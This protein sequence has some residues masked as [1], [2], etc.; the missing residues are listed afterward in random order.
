MKLCMFH[1]VDTP[2]ERGWVGRIEGD[3]VV[4]LAA[5][6]LQHLF[7]GGGSARDHARYRARRRRARRPARLSPVGPRLRR[8]RLVRVRESGGA[9]RARGAGHGPAGHHA[10]RARRR[11]RRARR[12][13]GR[14]CGLA[15]RTRSR[16]GAAPPKDRDFAI[17]LGPWF[18]TLDEAPPAPA[19]TVDVADAPHAEATKT[20]RLG[21]GQGVRRS[22]TPGS[23]SATFCS[24][25]PRPSWRCSRA[26]PSRSTSRATAP[27][28]SPLPARPK[29]TTGV[30]PHLPAARR[31]A[32][33]RV[34]DDPRADAR[35]APRRGGRRRPR[36]RQP[37]PPL[38]GRGRR[39][40]PGGGRQAAQPPLLRVQGHPQAPRG[41]RRPLPAPFG[42]ELDPE[43]QVVATM[44]AKEGLVHL[45]WTLVEP[46]DAALVPA[47]SYPIHIHAP[48]LAGAS[49]FQVAMAPDQDLFANLADA[50]ARASPRPRVL[51]LSFPHNPTTATVELEFM[52]RVVGIRPRAR[53]PRRPRLRL[54]RPRLRR[55]RAALDP[56]GSR[57]DRRRSGAL[58]ADEVVL[59]GRLAR[60]L[61]RRQRAG[62]RR[63]RAAQ[64]LA[65]LRDLPADPDRRH[66]RDERGAGHAGR[67]VRGLPLTA[68]RALRR[69]RPCRLVVPEAARDDVRVGSR[70]RAVRGDGLA[71]VRRAPRT[72]GAGGRVPRLGLRAGRRGLRPLRPRRERAPHPPGGARDQARA[73]RRAADQ[74]PE[75]KPRPDSR[76]R[77]RRPRAPGRGARPPPRRSGRATR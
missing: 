66:H 32:P 53:D 65:R 23:A 74:P 40:A 14:R 10:A 7:T 46:G 62:L 75:A 73:G 69:P 50:Y 22:R 51:L 2:M 54:R 29:R 16:A 30:T 17:V 48:M 27:S 33:V 43:T 68:R 15:R 37:R 11:A 60:R 12:P 13:R 3:E 35:A 8:R 76:R 38:A 5:Q 26:P 55:P 47:P 63:A 31:P 71:R 44:G 45:M 25:P 58:H 20:V 57:G 56:A 61:P 9:R 70:S 52:E 19:V 41:L 72:G 59:D 36:L 67:G 28:P 34:R 1:P 64:E 18:T 77:P 42:V 39:E 6:T 4:H 24:R 49:V 21:G